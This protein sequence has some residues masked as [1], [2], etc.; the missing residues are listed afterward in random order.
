MSEKKILFL[1]GTGLIGSHVLKILSKNINNINALSRRSNNNYPENVKDT[2]FNF[3]T[4]LNELDLPNCDHLFICIGRSLKLSELLYIRKKDRKNH[5]KIEHDYVFNLAKKAKE[6]GTNNLSIIS[7]VG[8][9]SNSSNFYL[10]TK[11]LIEEDLK[12]LRYKN[13][14][15]LRPGHII[16]NKEINEI[17]FL[18]WVIDILFKLVNPFLKSSLRKY[19]GIP[20]ERVSEFMANEEMAG[21]KIFYYDDF[22]K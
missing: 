19:R 12:N 18:V 11:G 7:A 16:T 20:L 6:M 3:D 13:I 5:F 10:S 4:P 17:G 15:I 9:N 1:G 8:A 14:N 22:I 21:T 2:F